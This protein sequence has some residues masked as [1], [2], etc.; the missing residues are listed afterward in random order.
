MDGSGIAQSAGS[1][2]LGSAGESGRKT[3]PSA[4]RMIQRS[5]ASSRPVT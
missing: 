2:V 3:L 1:G 4:R 5:V